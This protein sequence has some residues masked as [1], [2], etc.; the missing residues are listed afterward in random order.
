VATDRIQ[1]LVQS[2]LAG[3]S[4][5]SRKR[6]RDLERPPGLQ[7]KANWEDDHHYWLVLGPGSVLELAEVTN[8]GSLEILAHRY[9]QL[10]RYM[11]FAY[12]ET[13]GAK[14]S[15]FLIF[16]YRASTWYPLV[17]APGSGDAKHAEH[18]V[19]GGLRVERDVELERQL[20]ARLADTL[21]IVNSADD[22][23]QFPGAPF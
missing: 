19:D 15:V 10:L 4:W 12:R 20:Q 8:D 23:F 3:P 6:R 7:L 16:N 18:D 22:W 21:P 11:V 17:P 2:L 1:P 14:R 5:Q 13:E 9:G